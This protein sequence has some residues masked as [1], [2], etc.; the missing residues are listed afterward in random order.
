MQRMKQYPIMSL[1]FNPST[2]KRVVPRT[3]E[4]N[5]SMRPQPTAIAIVAGSTPNF[6][7][8]GTCSGPQS[9][10]SPPDGANKFTNPA[11][12]YV[13]IS[14]VS[15]DAMDAI[16]SMIELPNPEL[17]KTAIIPHK[18]ETVE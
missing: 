3:A 6:N 9:P 11:D 7:P 16:H 4:S 5:L 10:L 8:A 2:P 17:P 12:Q 14:N 18:M 15:F 1:I 13:N